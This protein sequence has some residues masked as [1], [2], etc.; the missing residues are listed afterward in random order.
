MDFKDLANNIAAALVDQLKVID[1]RQAEQRSRWFQKDANGVYQQVRERY[2]IG[3]EEIDVPVIGMEQPSRLDIEE[4][5]AKV[6]TDV[7]FGHQKG[8]RKLMVRMFAGAENKSSEIKVTIKLKRSS[9][10]EGLLAFHKHGANEIKDK[11][12]SLG[13][14]GDIDGR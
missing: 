11:L 12:A 3:D 4:F 8:L 2:K 14:E 6:D 1:E 13:G 7:G 10:S 5:E 9:P